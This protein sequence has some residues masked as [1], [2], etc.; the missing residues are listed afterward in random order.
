MPYYTSN[1]LNLH[2]EEHGQGTPLILVHGFAQD[3][4]AWVDPRWK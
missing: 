4:T 1:G 2:Y 3:S